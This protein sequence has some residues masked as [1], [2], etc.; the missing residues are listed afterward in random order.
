LFED[1]FLKLHDK[2]KEIKIMGIW[3][4]DGL[5]LEKKYFSEMSEVDLELTGAELAD[6]ISKLNGMKLSMEKYFIT[7]QFKGYSLLVFSLTSDYFLMV[8]TD[9]TIIPGKLNFYFNLYKN[10]L[11]SAL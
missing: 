2:N 10:K 6:I 9:Q 3:G 11:I 1:I 4:K 8:V 5:V 7:L